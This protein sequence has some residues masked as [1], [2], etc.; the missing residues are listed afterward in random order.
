MKTPLT[1]MK[2]RPFMR[3]AAGPGLFRRAWQSGAYRNVGDNLRSNACL[4]SMVGTI[5]TLKDKGFG[6]IVPKD[7]SKDVFFHAKVT[8][9][10]RFNDLRVGDVVEYEVEET[11]RGIAASIVTPSVEV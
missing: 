2:Y 1:R 4:R 3:V 10:K 9:E 11:D 8:K 5:R 7:G 6:F